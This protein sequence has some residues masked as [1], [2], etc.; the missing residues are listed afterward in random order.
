MTI[1]DA[2]PWRK[3][4][5][6]GWHDWSNVL[7]PGE[8]TL[9]GQSYNLKRFYWSLLSFEMLMAWWDT[10]YIYIILFCSNHIFDAFNSIAK[11]K[12]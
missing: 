6:A 8:S 7:R 10:L 4:F 1:L 9:S 2:I 11:D 5:A 12:L 3:Y